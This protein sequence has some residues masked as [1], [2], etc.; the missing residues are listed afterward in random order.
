MYD[1]LL[2]HN[3]NFI[4]F[5]H[6]NNGSIIRNSWT[7]WMHHLGT[8]ILFAKLYL[9]IEVAL[10]STMSLPSPCT[11]CA[12]ELDSFRGYWRYRS[13]VIINY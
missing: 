10:Y 4:W 6:R 3:F 5:S 8:C 9:N 1:P 7:Q 12:T 2:N 13:F 11:R